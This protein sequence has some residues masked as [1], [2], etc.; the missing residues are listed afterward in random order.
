MDRNGYSDSILQD[1]HEVCFFWPCPECT[2]DKLDRHEVFGG[3]LRQKSKRYGLWVSICHCGC[4]LGD[5]GVHA[6]REKREALQRFAQERA[7]AVYGW[8]E[9][10]FRKEFYKSYL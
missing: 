6:N 5:H 3:P 2:G 7:M 1:D 4:H 8:T 9:D 10:D